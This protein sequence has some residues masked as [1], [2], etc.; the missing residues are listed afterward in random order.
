[1]QYILGSIFML[2][3]V[4]LLFFFSYIV[5]PRNILKYKV[6]PSMKPDSLSDNL[7]NYIPE[8]ENAEYVEDYHI[9]IDKK[10]AKKFATINFKENVHQV[11]LYLVLFNLNNRPFAVKK[12]SIQD[13]QFLESKNILIPNET[14]GL[15]LQIVS[16][17]DSQFDS[18]L[19]IYYTNKSI[20]AASLIHSIAVLLCSILFAY[21]LIA[22]PTAMSADLYFILFGN[23]FFTLLY[24]FALYVVSFGACFFLT[25]FFNKKYIKPEESL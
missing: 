7:K 4:L 21:G 13:A 17:D 11:E 24:S 5:Y 18:T 9:S 10:S 15:Y 20:V 8:K 3:A 6:L 25:W 12:V 19:P 1:M 16:A 14:R 2:L 23:P 22:M